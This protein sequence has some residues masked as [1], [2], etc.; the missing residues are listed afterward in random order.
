MVPTSF[1]TSERTR[2]IS[3][4]SVG[5]SRQCRASVKS[6]PKCLSNIFCVP[7]VSVAMFG[8]RWFSSSA[9]NTAASHSQ[10]APCLLTSG[11]FWCSP[12]QA[13]QRHSGNSSTNRSVTTEKNKLL[14]VCWAAIDN[15]SKTRSTAATSNCCAES[16]FALFASLVMGVL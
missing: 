6:G 4:E 3:L 14:S 13:T 5:W 15:S 12:T 2:N 8:S 10:L 16:S 7:T 9:G 11:I 1:S